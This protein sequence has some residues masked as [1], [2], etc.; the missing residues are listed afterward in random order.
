MADWNRNTRILYTPKKPLR[1]RRMRARGVLLVCVFLAGVFLF[2]LYWFFTNPKFYVSRILIEGA[3]TV[4][5]AD[6][7]NSIRAYGAL[8]VAGI[9]SR[10]HYLLFSSSKVEKI[11]QEQFPRIRDIDV[12]KEFSGEIR[13]TLTERTPWG[14]VCAGLPPS[15]PPG[16][17]NNREGSCVFIDESGFAFEKAPY[18]FGA[19]TKKIFVDSEN[20]SIGTT[21]IPAQYIAMYESFKDALSPVGIAVTSLAFLKDAPR[22][23]RIYSGG[24]YT[25]VDRDAAAA[26]I[27]SVLKPLLETELSGKLSSVEYIDARFGNKVFYKLKK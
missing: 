21:I 12:K 27:A 9:F 15:A 2:G 22:D 17:T 11:I 4:S 8:S 5:P 14:S 1:A 23:I 16:E 7:E 19:L 18:F 24:W 25:I 20:L 26:D 10:S 13:V 6:I 3:K